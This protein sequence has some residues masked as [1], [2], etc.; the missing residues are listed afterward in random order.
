MAL[1]V[2]KGE[3][4]SMK[5]AL[6][7]II[8]VI[9]VVALI[10]VSFLGVRAEVKNQTIEVEGIVLNNQ[11]M[12][13]P[14][15]PETPINRYLAVYQRPEADKIDE[16]GI[17][18]I[19]RVNWDFNGISRD[20]AIYIDDYYYFYNTG[21]KYTI[22]CNVVPSNATKKELTYSLLAS[23]A[24]REKVQ[25]AQNELTFSFTDNRSYVDFDV[26]VRSKDLSGVE[27]RILFKIG[28][29]DDFDW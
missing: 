23:E 5:K 1:H 10:I 24:M 28:P 16:D 17:G 15:L 26:I 29:Y 12:Y 8:S 11:S 2:Q 3:I 9:Y 6:I 18:K 14:G 22:D 13:Y 25:L 7:A 27:I 19:D 21:R 20:Y 4:I